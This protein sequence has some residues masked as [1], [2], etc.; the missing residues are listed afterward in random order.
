LDGCNGVR[1]GLSATPNRADDL[2]Q[3]VFDL[4]GPIVCIID[5]KELIETGNL[6]KAKVIFHTP[7]SSQESV[8]AVR[9][10]A[11][12]L[13]KDM[14]RKMRFIAYRNARGD[15]AR[16]KSE[17]QVLIKEVKR[18]VIWQCAANVGIFNNL[19]RD[20][21]I[22]SLAVNHSSDSVLMIVGS[23]DH[24][25]RLADKIPGAVMVYSKIGVKKRREAMEGFKSGKINCLI[26]TSLAD[27]G[28]DVQRANVLILTSGG[29]SAAKA[30][31]RTGRVLRSFQGK[32]HGL[33]HDFWD[34]QHFFL[35]AQ[36]KARKRVYQQL[37]YEII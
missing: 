3:D 18:R 19:K 34:Q 22:V 25:Q 10:M 36:S 16:F 4:I 21:L 11:R 24:G 6:A 26:A 13:I 28:L 14:F 31:Q 29:R 23:I 33:I 1:W 2:K 9:N 32:E 20:D 17:Q 5:R 30:E 7:N 8:L 12:P 15:K 35:L 37:G 27:E